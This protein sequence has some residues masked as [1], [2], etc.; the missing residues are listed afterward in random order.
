M[1][2]RKQAPSIV[3]DLVGFQLEFSTQGESIEDRSSVILGAALLEEHLQRLISG[4][5]V[6]DSRMMSGLFD[7]NG[8]F[9]TFGNKIKVAYS[10]GLISKDEFCNLEIIRE[11]RN[12]FAHQLH[13]VSFMDEW[14]M[15]KLQNLNIP[16]IVA[17]D[18]PVTPQIWF[19]LVVYVLVIQIKYRTTK[20]EQTRRHLPDEL[21][22][23]K[24]DIEDG[25]AFAPFD[26]DILVNLGY[27]TRPKIS[28]FPTGLSLVWKRKQRKVEKPDEPL[29]S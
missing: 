12:V 25:I 24:E 13:D 29:H 5:L 15:N 21:P 20:V 7:F 17:P 16:K 9:G 8:P 6:D 23:W 14:V 28:D 4:F 18:D 22:W 19:Q 3:D 26:V 11:I 10:L 2:K 27:G 1:A